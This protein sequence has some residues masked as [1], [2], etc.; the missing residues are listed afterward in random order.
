MSSDRDSSPPPSVPPHSHNHKDG[1]DVDSSPTQKANMS[2]AAKL[3]PS[4]PNLPTLPRKDFL[5][6]GEISPLT[7]TNHKRFGDKDKPASTSGDSRC[8]SDVQKEEVDQALRDLKTGMS[9]SKS[10]D[11]SVARKTCNDGTSLA[12]S[13]A[14]LLIFAF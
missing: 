9:R 7:I 6:D 13:F 12:A 1:N 10:Y 11:E 3:A 5:C 2:K 4:E 8:K 14:A